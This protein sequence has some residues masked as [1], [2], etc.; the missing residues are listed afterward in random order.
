MMATTLLLMLCASAMVVTLKLISMT[1]RRGTIAKSHVVLVASTGVCGFS[2]ALFARSLWVTLHHGS[3]GSKSLAAIIVGIVASAVMG[4]TSSWTTDEFAFPDE[5]DVF[6]PL[7]I[8]GLGSTGG[9]DDNLLHA[10]CSLKEPMCSVASDDTNSRSSFPPSPLP[11]PTYTHAPT[12]AGSSSALDWHNS[13]SNPPWSSLPTSIPTFAIKL[14]FD[15]AS[16][17]GT[18]PTQYGL[19]TEVT[20]FILRSNFIQGTIP[21]EMGKMVNLLSGFVLE[22]NQLRGSLPTEIGSHSKL[23]YWWSVSDNYLSGTLPSQLGNLGELT[24]ALQVSDNGLIGTLPTELGS[25]E[26]LRADVSFDKQTKGW[27]RSGMSG[28]MPTELGRWS[29]MIMSMDFSTNL[30]Q[31]TI[32]TQLGSL[33]GME[34]FF[35]FAANK[36]SNTLPTQLGRLS[37]LTFAL[38]FR[39]NELCG[40][41]PS[42]LQSLAGIEDAL[43]VTNGNSIGTTCMD[44]RDIS[45]P[46]PLPTDLPTN[47]KSLRFVDSSIIGTI[48]TQYGRYT[49]A[50]EFLL[51]SNSMSGTIPSELGLMTSLEST[52][53]L[54]SNMLTGS[55]PTELFGHTK[56]SYF[57]SI[58]GN[59]F[60]QQ[61][62]TQIGNLAAMTELIQLSENKLWGTV[63]SQLGAL[64]KLT[65]DLIMNGNCIGM[66]NDH[67]DMDGNKFAGVIPTQLGSLSKLKRVLDF[68][69]NDLEGTIVTEL[70]QLSQLEYYF[71]FRENSLRGSLP[72]QLGLLRKLTAQM[73]L[74]ENSLC[75]EIPSEVRA[76]SGNIV[77]MKLIDGN[78]LGTPCKT[79][80][81][82]RSSGG[83]KRSAAQE[84]SHLE[85]STYEA[86]R[87]IWTVP[88]TPAAQGEAECVDFAEAGG[89]RGLC[90]VRCSGSCNCA[91]SAQQRTYTALYSECH[92][93]EDWLGEC[94]TG[95]V[96]TIRS[97]ATA[98]FAVAWS[99]L[100]LSVLVLCLAVSFRKAR[101]P[102]LATFEVELSSFEQPH[103]PAYLKLDG[104]R[105]GRIPGGPR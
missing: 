100:A 20:E 51:V 35:R 91:V 65:S 83:S 13:S 24:Q 102:S 5:C 95:S 29:K 75:G 66:S 98:Q 56:M 60:I 92:A 72:S 79:V 42:Q 27:P 9:S 45:I 38:D 2:T 23:S 97:L 25:L 59:S 61:C 82:L 88:A 86:T 101:V 15:S 10:Q 87:T 19:L 39:T 32:A 73:Q 64:S 21:S 58:S 28:S 96:R 67:F 54:Q 47:S 70:G 43:L 50:T 49:Q 40:Q 31:S 48:P 8:Y 55:I 26:K 37:V 69:F 103:P 94:S 34:Y 76:I 16:I 105:G 46:M 52:F 71:S 99:C 57:W 81:A 7:T 44:W 33:T 53:V 78:S 93:I 41:V 18:I 1:A 68:S 63:P 4:A 77:G 3:T 80:R 11:V 17:T 14:S 90:A 89:E 74:D 30:L 36:L 12:P 84:A 6:T 85:L 62:P 104:E 22:S